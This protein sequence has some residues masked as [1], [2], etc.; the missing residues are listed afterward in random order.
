M[1]YVK[2]DP[3]EKHLEEA[4]P[5]HPSELYFILM[6]DPFERSFLAKGICRKIG[7]DVIHCES[8]KLLEE[9]ESPSLFSEKRV[10]VC[11]TPTEKEIPKANDLIMIFTG[12]SPPLFYKG[13]EKMGT[14]LDLSG[15]KPWD[16]KNRLQRWL[17]GRAREKG[18]ILSDDGVAY[19]LDF[20]HADFSTLLQELDKVVVYSGEEKILTL[21]M[22]KTICTIDPVQDGWQLSE[23]VVLG[24]PIHFG[25]TDLY[26]L[27][28]QLRYQLQL[29][30]QIASAKEPAKVSPK[31]L[32][33]F[34][35][36]R[37]QT[38][39]FMEGMKDLFDLEMKMRSNSS[40]QGLLFDQFRAKLAVRR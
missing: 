4:L 6:E 15:E 18:K 10:L 30:L 33:R 19:L 3:F 5:D 1:K 14:T 40:N 28:G 13:M 12:K 11:D 2:I 25:E 20:S 39:F 32:E 36:A 21:E 24:G 27:I 38:V 16:R 35:K 7:L 23:A 8:E 37:L 9:L 26:A 22:I 29:G 31:K 34:R 17:L